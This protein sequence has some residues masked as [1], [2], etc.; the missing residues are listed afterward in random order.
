MNGLRFDDL[1][2]APAELLGR[3]KNGTVYKVVC[4]QQGMVLAVKR[5]RDWVISSSDFRVRMKRLD[6][7]RHPNVLSAMAFYYSKQEKLLVYEYQQNGSL[8]RLLHGNFIPSIF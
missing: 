3:G 2:R 8:F 7:V 4:E 5:V 1:L 6:Q